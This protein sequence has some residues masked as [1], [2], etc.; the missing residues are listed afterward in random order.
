MTNEAYYEAWEY[1]P[2]LVLSVA[3]FTLAQLLGSLY[4]TFKKTLM[5]FVTNLLTAIINVVLNI[6]LIP[7][8]GIQGACITT[9]VSYLV[10]WIIRAF[11]TRRLLRIKYYVIRTVLNC[12]LLTVQS[13]IVVLEIQL[14]YV[15]AAVIILLLLIR[16]GW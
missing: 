14:W 12:V 8:F 13:I 10:L 9:A 4:T 6:I 16:N 2:V 5:A 15:Y 3:F 11:D 1:V 7:R